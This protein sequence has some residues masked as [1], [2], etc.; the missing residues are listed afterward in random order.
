M[1]LERGTLLVSSTRAPELN[2]DSCTGPEPCRSR[3]TWPAFAL[4]AAISPFAALSELTRLA[5]FPR[6]RPLPECACR[7][8]FAGT[9][10]E[11]PYTLARSLQ[12]DRPMRT[13]VTVVR[14]ERRL[15]GSALREPQRVRWQP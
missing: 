15:D 10:R 4:R 1:L 14:V 7:V 12:V 8:S 6:A 9:R 5:A 2:Q 13:R 11:K 3:S